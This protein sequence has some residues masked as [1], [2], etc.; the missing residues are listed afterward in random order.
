M[1]NISDKAINNASKNIVDNLGNVSD[2]N[3]MQDM[4]HEISDINKIN[5]DNLNII[6]FDKR[7]TNKTLPLILKDKNDSNPVIM[8][9]N[10]DQV[11]I[12]SLQTDIR[13]IYNFIKTLGGGA[14]YS[15]RLAYKINDES[16]KLFVIK[17]FSKLNIHK[18]EL[19]I[20]S[21]VLNTLPKL[22]HPNLIQFY[23]TYNDKYYLHIVMEYCE[24]INLLDYYKTN[25]HRLSE[26]NCIKIINNLLTLTNYCQKLGIERVNLKPDNI[27]I[28]EQEKSKEVEKKDIDDI[29]VVDDIDDVAKENKE[30]K[31]DIEIKLFSLGFKGDSYSLRES[32]YKKP[33]YFISPEEISNIELQPE[34]KEV[35]TIGIITYYL[36]GANYPFLS[37]GKGKGS[38][39][40]KDMYLQSQE[41]IN[42]SILNNKLEFPEI[43][44]EGVSNS[45][46]EFLNFLLNKDVDKR[47]TI[48]KCLEHKWMKPY[49]NKLHSSYYIR[50]VSSKVLANMKDKLNNNKF[51]NIILNYMIKYL[52]NDEVKKLGKAFSAI[53]V[54]NNGYINLKQLINGFQNANIELSKIEI[55]K[56]F[57]SMD[58]DHSGF[59][60]Y[61]EFLVATINQK[62]FVNKEK[63]VQIFQTFDKDNVGFISASNLKDLL[64]LSGKDTD[65]SKIESIIKEVTKT[66]CKDKTCMISLKE[67]L[68]L[69]G[70]NLD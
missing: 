48:Q 57:E 11:L 46:I 56:L 15:S 65:E 58:Y 18:D 6:K 43:H 31:D 68:N 20:L 24:G 60:D 21:N 55:E 32:P 7:T 36:L 27:I 45:A 12:N 53:D 10:I 67:Y 47:P 4:K 5:T 2:N 44:F 3:N 40:N 54:N 41:S 25:K 64:L 39:D 38:K 13:K 19:E 29:D 66:S 51:Q 61:N 69:F 30:N 59:I 8:D 37:H 14:F 49:L 28:L 23:E 63:L 52:S 70:I 26:S 33:D 62:T 50:K 35:W 17:S 9:I 34:K 1:G 22:S 16:K 42:F